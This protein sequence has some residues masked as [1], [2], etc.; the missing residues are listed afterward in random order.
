MFQHI[1]LMKVLHYQ[2]TLQKAAN[3][4]LLKQGEG[5]GNT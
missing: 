1:Q 3:P 4:E 2:L 5:R